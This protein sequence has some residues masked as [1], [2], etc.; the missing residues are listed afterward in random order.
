MKSIS[1][2]LRTG[3]DIY[4][5]DCQV[6][7]CCTGSSLYLDIRALKK[8]QDRL[9]SFAANF[10]NICTISVSID[11]PDLPA[12]ER[13]SLGDFS[14]CQTSTSLKIDVLRIDQSAERL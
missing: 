6:P 3:S 2:Y 10:T 1:E 7:K 4:T 8:E 13:T 9:K 12:A 5:V 11:R 14:E